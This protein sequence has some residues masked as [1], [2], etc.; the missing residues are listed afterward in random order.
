MT[1]YGRYRFLRL[2]F[3][4]VSVQDEFQQKM[5]ETFE[6]LPGVTPLVDD[7]I[8]TGRTWE[9]HDTILRATLDRAA[10]KNLKLNPDKLTVGA[11]EVEYF[12]HIISADGLKPDPTKVK[13][14]QDMPPPVDKKKPQTMLGMINY[15]AQFAP[16]LS[17]TTKPIR[18]LKDD[19][20]FL[21]DQPQRDA[22]D[23]TKAIILSQPVLSFFDQ[24]KP[25][26]LQVDASKHGLGAA[27]FQEDKSVAFASKSLNKTEQN[28]AQIQKELYAILFGCKKFHHHLYGHKVT[29]QSDHKPLE[30]IMK[31]PLSVAPPRLQRMLLQLQKYDLHVVHVPG[32]NTPVAD[33]LSRI[34]LQAE[35]E[36]NDTV[37]DV[38][39]Q[40]NCLFNNMPVT[41]KEMK[42]LRQTTAE[43]PQMQE[44][45]STILEGW[46]ELR[47]NCKPTI[48][49][50]WNF[51]DQLSAIDGIIFKGEKI[52]VPTSLRPEMIQKIHSS[53]LGREKTKQRAR[54]I[55]FWPGMATQIHNAVA[56]APSA[57]Q[58]DPPTPNN[59]SCHTK[60][61]PDPGRSLP[62]TYSRGT[63]DRS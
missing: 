23:R 26:T 27:L 53:H 21:W 43:D 46:P 7:I 9:E 49:E 17:E 8:V 63:K 15:L 36:D 47:Q 2:P 41:D 37:E 52:L 56:A 16:Q 3:G 39:V 5:D 22:V 45:L 1:S 58:L 48:S 13:A 54:D 28:Y 38:N 55:L 57:L 62:L 29:V 44:L 33:T 4:I 24:A 31:K 14:I 51:R 59:L 30:S 35:P 19:A 32:K 10:A 42:Q 50:F 11:H 34:F 6:G 40:V 25:I 20:E 61:H 12:G 18:D 60:S